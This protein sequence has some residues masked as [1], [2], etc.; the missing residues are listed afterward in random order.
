M[1][2]VSAS[3]RERRTGTWLPAAAVTRPHNPQLLQF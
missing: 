2:Q 1:S 3:N